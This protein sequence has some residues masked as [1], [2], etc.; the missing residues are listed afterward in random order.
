MARRADHRRRVTRLRG[1]SASA[2]SLSGPSGRTVSLVPYPA[3][4]SAAKPDLLDGFARTEAQFAED[5]GLRVWGLGQSPWT[6]DVGTAARS[7]A[8]RCREQ[9]TWVATVADRFR[10]ADR[11]VP[12]VLD[13][14]RL[15]I[16]IKEGRRDDNPY[17]TWFGM[18][19]APWCAAFVSWVFAH[20]GAKLP[21]MQSAKGFMRVS[22]GR[23]WARTHG[24]LVDSPRPGDV[25]F[26]VRRNGTG[27][28]GIVEKV[29]GDGTITTIEGNTNGSGSR[30]GDRVARRVR[31]VVSINGGFMR[32]VGPID[33]EDVVRTR[34][35]FRVRAR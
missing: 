28:T 19:N 35:A 5:L 34:P 32:P 21:P 9:A 33:P 6:W 7:H 3:V 23:E 14:A 2:P 20:S 29:N 17:G 18:N 4:I 1:A 30:L 31:T 16:G 25:F 13:L 22:I 8:S 27:H 15:Q 10:Q 26:I 12:A 24:R 11:V